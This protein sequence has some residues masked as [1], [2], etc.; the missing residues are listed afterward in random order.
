MVSLRWY[1]SEQESIIYVLII[2]TYIYKTHKRYKSFWKLSICVPENTSQRTKGFTLKK[3]P[4]DYPGRLPEIKE[5]YPNGKS[6][7][8]RL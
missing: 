3:I 5:T 6:D 4:V 8:K 1:Y 7:S 2:L